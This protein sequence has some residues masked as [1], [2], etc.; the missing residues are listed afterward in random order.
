MT[1][2]SS[3]FAVS[4]NRYDMVKMLQSKNKV[5]QLTEDFSELVSTVQSYSAFVLSA[6]E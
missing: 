1:R 3:V 6:N 5:E 4:W 2:Q